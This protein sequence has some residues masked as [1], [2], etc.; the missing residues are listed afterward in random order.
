MLPSIKVPVRPVN[1][2]TMSPPDVGW[3]HGFTHYVDK[4]GFKMGFCGVNYFEEHAVKCEK[5][6]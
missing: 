6:L 4:Y 1:G 5:P 3:S 2:E